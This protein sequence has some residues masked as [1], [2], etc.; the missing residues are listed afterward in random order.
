LSDNKNLK[1]HLLSIILLLSLQNIVFAQLNATIS[2]TE[3]FNCLGTPCNYSGPGILINEIMLSPASNDGSLSGPVG[4]NNPGRGEWIELYNPNLCEAVDISCYMLGNNAIVSNN[5]NAGGG[6]RIPPGTIVPPAGFVLLRGVNADPIPLNRLIQNGGNVIELIIPS[7]ITDPGVCVGQSGTR[8]WFP[9]AGGWFAFYDANGVPQDAI[10]WGSQANI[11]LEPCTPAFTGCGFNGTL[12]AYNNIPNNRKTFVTS[13]Q[14]GSNTFGLSLKRVPDGGTWGSTFSAPSLSDCN[15][16]CINLLT[17][18]CSGTATVVVTGGSGNYS[19]KWDDSQAQITATAINLCGEEY[20]VI[21]KDLTTL[22]SLIICVE[23]TNFE[24]VVSFGLIDTLCTSESGFFVSGGLPVAGPNEQGIYSGTGIINGVF[25]PLIANQGLNELKYTYTSEGGC[26]DSAFGEIYVYEPLIVSISGL[27]PTYCI[28]DASSQLS[29]NPAGGVISVTTGLSGNIFNPANALIGENLISYTVV[30]TNSCTYIDSAITKVFPKPIITHAP[31]PG[32]CLNETNVILS[33]ANPTGGTYFG[34]GI[35][36]NNNFEPSL[37]GVG[38]HTISYTYV[39]TAGCTDTISLSVEVFDVPTVVFNP[40]GDFCKS[41]SSVVLNSAS[42]L[43]GIY[44][45]NGV[46]NGVFNP[47]LANAGNNMITYSLTDSSGCIVR[48]TINVVVIDASSIIFSQLSD[49]CSNEA[50]FVLNIASPTGGV[51][52]GNGIVNGVFNPALANVGNNMIYYNYSDSIGCTGEDSISVNI[53]S[54][55]IITAEPDTAFCIGGCAQLSATEGGLSY[56]WSP[57][58]GLS[59]P[60]IANPTACP[61]QTTTYTVTVSL[62][63][64]NLVQNGDFSQ[65]NTGF[66]SAYTR[67]NSLLLS[68]RYNIV[69]DANNAYFTFQG[70][71]HT[72]PPNGLFMVVN[73]AGTTGVNVWCQTVT[74]APN[75]DYILSTW[76][77]SVVSTNP[78]SLRFRI[79]G[80]TQ[81]AVFSPPS[82][83]GDWVLFSRVWNSGNATTADICI[84]NMNNSAN[85]N[86]FGLDDISFSTICDGTAQVTVTVNPY[87]VLDFDDSLNVCVNNQ[88]FTLNNVTPTGGTYSGSG[89]VNGDFDP[90]LANIGNNTITYSYTDSIGCSAV[91]SFNILVNN[92]IDII[93]TD[94]DPVCVDEASFVLNNATPTGGI[95]SGSGVSNGEFNPSLANIGDNLITY[96]YADSLGCSGVDSFIIVVNDLPVISFDPINNICIDE[97]PFALNFAS[98]IGGTYSG[99]GIANGE[100]DPSLAGV[101]NHFIYYEYTDSLGCS[102]IDSIEIIVFELPIISFN[103]IGDFCLNDSSVLLNSATPI[104]GTYSGNGVLNGV[105]DPSLAGVGNHIIYYQYTDSNSCGAIDSIDVIVFDTPVI[106]LTNI[107]P[108]CVD[109]ASFVLNNA[110]P[111]GGTYS[112]SGVSNAEFNPSLANI[113]NN[114]IIYDYTDSLSCSAVDSFVIVVNDL[115]IISFNSI[116][117]ICIDENPFTL[118]FASPIGGTYSGNGIANVEFDPSLAGVGNHFIYYEFTDSLGCSNI[119]SVEIIVFELPIISFNSIGDFCLNDSS[120]LLSSATP[121]G[122]TYSGNGVLNGIFDPSL[123]GVGNHKIYYQYTDSNSCGAI[124]SIDVIV[125]DT[126]VINFSNINPV[127]VDEAPFTLNNATPIG[128]TYSGSGVSNAEFNP[129]LANIGNNIIIYNYT[130]SL[131]CS[132]VDSFIIVVNDLPIISFNSINNI[133]ID[134]NPFTLNFASP[135]GGTY[136]GNGIANGEF[137]PSLAGVGNHFIYYEFTDSLSCSNIDSVEIIVYPLPIISFN[138]IGDFCINDASI[139]LNSATPIGGTYSGNGVT[140]GEFNPSLAGSGNHFVYYEFTDSLGCS[141]TDSIEIIV[142]PSPIITFNAVGNF[143]IDDD[144]ISLNSATP[145]GGT[146]FGNGVTNGVFDPSL[147][148]VGNHNIF[149]QYADSNSCSAIDSI[150][151][152]VFDLP[153]INFSNINPVCVDASSFT[154]NNATPLGGIY[155]G[156]AVANGDFNPSLANIGNNII[157]YDYTDSLGCS[158]VDTFTIVVNDLPIISFDSINSY[159]INEDPITLNFASPIGGTY[160]GNGVVNSAFDP[161]LAGVGNHIITYTFTDLNGCTNSDTA[162]IIVYDFPAIT[163]PNLGQICVNNGIVNIQPV[164]PIGGILSGNGVTTNQF[165]PEIAGVGNHWIVYEYTDSKGCSNSDSIEVEVLDL[166]TIVFPDYAPLCEVA[167]PFILNTALPSGGIYSGNAI[168]GGIFS[169]GNANLGNN[170][171]YYTYTDSLGCSIT[172][173]ANILIYNITSPP[174]DFGA[175]NPICV[176]SVIPLNTG[177]P[178]GGVY[179]GSGVVNNTFDAS[180]VGSGTFELIYTYTDPDNCVNSDTTTITVNPLPVIS[181]NS[182]ADVCINNPA[183]NLNT[184]TPV[185]GTY[186]GNGVNNNQFNPSNAGLNTHVINYTFTDNNNCVNSDSATVLV[187][188]TTPIIFDNLSAVCVNDSSFTLN[189]ALPVGGIYSGPGVSNGIFNPTI[190]GTG[191][192]TLTYTFANANGCINSET[193]TI[194]VNALPNITFNNLPDVCIDETPFTLNIAT[195]TGGTYSGVG[196]SNNQFNPAV[197]GAGTHTI[198]YTFTNNNNCTNTKTATITVNPLPIVVFNDLADKCINNPTFNLNT[199][200]P[201]GGTYSGNGVNNNQFIPSVAGVGTHT[202]IYTFTDN[203]SCSNSDSASII[204]NDTTPI[205]FPDFAPI[206]IDETPFTLNTALPVGG[207]YSGSGVSNGIYNPAVAGVGNRNITYRYTNNFGCINTKVA[208]IRINA[209]PNITFNNLPDVCIDETPFTLNIAT[210]TGGTYSG[211]GVSNNQFNPAVAGAGTH[212]ITYTFTNNNNCTNTKTATITVNPLPIVVFND[213]ADKCINNP[214]FNLNTAT[215]TGGTYSG[216]GVNNNQ[217]IPSVAG[218][219]THT[220]IYTFTDNNSCSNSDSA[221]IIVNDTTPIIFPDFAPICIDETPFTLNTALPVG[222]VY[223]GSGVSNGIY[224][225]A[226]AGVGNRSITYRYTN[227]FGCINTKVARIRINALPNI[228]FNNLPDVCIDETPFALNTATPTGGTYSGVGVSNNQFN[229]A[230]AGVGTHTITYTFTNNNNCTNTKTATITVNPLPIIVFNDLADKCVNNPI[231]N[232]NTATPTGGI[233]SGNGVSNNQFSPS[234]AGVGTHIITYIFTDNNSCSNSDSATIIVNDT[235]PI[236]FADFAPICID[237]TPFTLNTATPT[238]GIY[239]GSGVSNGI[240]NPAVA[241]VGNR[242]ITYRY[243][244]NFGCINTKVARIRI[245]A[246]PNITFNN[247]LDVC[248]DETPFTLNTATPTGGTYSGV[249]VSNNQF[250][251]SI[252]GAGT[253]TITYTFTNNNNCTNTKTATI[254]V[255]PLPVLVFNDL[256]DKCINNPTFNLNTATPTSGTYSGNGVSNNQFSPSVAGVGT[257]II[258]YIFTDNNSCSNSDSATI[259]VNDT[260][261][262]IFPD[263]APICIDETPFT[264]NTASPTGGIY[265]GSGVSNGVYNPA[266]AGVGNRSVT[267]RY[268]NNFGCINTKVAR[269]RI[270]ALPNI[271]FNN[272]P[273]VCIDETPFTL[274]TATPTGGTYSGVGVSN[275]QFNPSIAGAG[276]HTITYTFTNN[277]NCTNTKTAIITVNPLPVVVFNDLADKCINNPILNLITATPSGG[278]YSGNGVSNN[279]FSPSVA[280]VGT[281]TITYIFT[282]NNSCSNLDSATIIVNDT[283]PIIFPDFAPI[284]IDEAPFTLSAA[285][286]TGGIYSGTGVSNGIYNPAVAGVGN[287]SIT[288]RYTNNFGCINTKVARIRINALPNITFNNLPDVCIDET[289]FTL[290]TATPTGGTYSG[291][292]VSNNQF[293]PAVAGAGTHTITYTFTNNNNCTNT[294][295]ATITVN[296]L[297]VVVFNNLADK[298]INNP[299]FNLNTATP[300]GGTYSGNGVSNNQFSPS[301]AGV[302]THTII[303]TF[304]DNNSCSN[305]DSASIIVNDTTP[306]IFPDFAPICIDETPFTLNTAS[307]TG[308]IYSGSGV[309]NGIYNPAVAGVGNRS[310]TYRY[311]NNFGCINTKMARIRINALPNITFNNLPDVCI[312]ETP[313][314]LNTATPTGGTYSGVGVSNNQFNP[315]IAGAGTHTITYTFT[316]NNNCTNTKTATITVNPLPVVVFNDLADKCINNPIFNLNTATPTGGIY[317]GNGVS[318]NQFSPS[319]AGVGTHT[320]IYI[321]TDN[322]SCSNSD[323]AT[324]IVNDTTP[325]IFPDF[326]PICINETPFTLN[327]ATPTGGIYTGS[328]VSNGIYNPAVAGVGNRS[329]TYRYTNNFGCINTKVARI[330][331]NA[332]PNI[333]FNNLPDVCV[334]ETPF[335]LNTATPTGGTYS[336]VGVSNNEFNPSVAGAGTHTITYSFTNT[337]NCTNTRTATIT[338]NPLPVVVFN[339]PN[340]VCVNSSVFNLNNVSPNGGTFSGTGVTNDQFNPSVA[341]AG[342]FI[343]TYTITDNNG[344]TNFDNATMV[345]NDTTPIVFNNIPEICEDNPPFTLVSASPTGGVYSGTGVLNNIFYPNT[346][347]VGT[348]EI[349][350]VYTNNFSCVNSKKNFVTVNPLPIV[351]AFTPF[352]NICPDDT[353]YIAV[354]GANNYFINP[355]F[356]TISFAND[357][358]DISQNLANTYVVT[359]IDL[360]GCQNKD[361]V[362]IGVF[363]LPNVSVTPP[364]DTICN[365]DSIILNA[366]GALNYNWFPDSVLISNNNDNILALP[367]SS[368]EFIVIGTDTNG[369][370][371]S[372]T[373]N[374]T[375]SIQLNISNV[376]TLCVGTS[377]VLTASE[378]GNYIWGPSS[379]LNTNVGQSVIASPTVTTTY[380]L[381][382]APKYGCP[383]EGTATVYVYQPLN[384]FAL[385]DTI[386]FNDTANVSAFGIGGDGNYSF[387]W[388][389]NNEFINPND[390]NAQVISQQTTNYTVIINDGCGSNSNSTTATVLVLPLPSISMN[391]SPLIGCQP[392]T[393]FLSHSSANGVSCAWYVDSL[394]FDN[395]CDTSFVFLD[396][397]LHSVTLVLE[398]T[399]GCFN[400]DTAEVIVLPRPIADFEHSFDPTTIIYPEVNFDGTVS[401]PDV[402]NWFWIFDSL[403]VGSGSQP[404]YLFENPHEYEVTLIVNNIEGCYDTITYIVDVKPDYAIY[405]PNAFTPNKDGKNDGFGPYGIGIKNGPGEYSMKIFNRW[406]E[407]IFESNDLNKFWNGIPEKS[408]NNQIAQNGIYVYVIDVIDI[409]NKK[410]QYTGKVTLLK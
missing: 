353:T 348:F 407:L 115:P 363:S 359:G 390:A 292:G 155:S 278:T 379:S 73:A 165:N 309:S 261:P 144:S 219:G 317:S 289:P 401:S 1:K 399:N 243:T 85:G 83:V 71:D 117:N 240:Y 84:Q 320:I 406:G 182:L 386:C 37:V 65:G 269:I 214:T 281:H 272:L 57:T 9:N 339:D 209:L 241:G 109:E 394:F 276:T 367:Y 296:P 60:S 39:D 245:N 391:V 27:N 373:A 92:F 222:G 383:N 68:G 29:F 67:N 36:A 282:D 40:I 17:S 184:A 42:P 347:G 6:Y 110:T 409:F 46:V 290:N 190:A 227:N 291:V 300:T 198:T 235:T 105:F 202:I 123:A 303:Y 410:H 158:A 208:R 55:P 351:S 44:A 58:T 323:S 228:T 217:F 381:L 98:P 61:T 378:P 380:F 168:V 183:F 362:S 72:N 101:G 283:T 147:A 197:A 252:A 151:I 258:T 32:I 45:G 389:P 82:T 136:S 112:G 33:G 384:V 301:A 64:G 138:S 177:I 257:H 307:P 166:P 16:S 52:S 192:K 247:L 118:N 387:E 48:D 374:I 175:L 210:P 213:L 12:P 338:V 91:D 318:N 30:D 304:T 349:T 116:N 288:Y 51:Y 20:C 25:D 162:S 350:Y 273:D 31:V 78:A 167:S 200:T 207:V 212:T 125:F 220:I 47:N 287:R 218:V 382:G 298:C 361:S 253:H 79:N 157:T 293:N 130:D 305:S 256:A 306:I 139:L 8:L 141:N 38:N 86:S 356:N 140:N 195:P 24:P 178:S 342:T 69:S 4:G 142:F 313:F 294:R 231:F 275:N 271:T 104:G 388:L 88:A 230:V 143:C 237:E 194:R 95:Y 393:T 106:N 248:I 13:T 341:G 170:T 43:G 81:G 268:T 15:S 90:S 369:C 312:D 370:K 365:G 265:T 277:N 87:P 246:L 19:Y 62:P 315:S 50:P 94:I 322:N 134:E 149:Y 352:N 201:T 314:T 215:P 221:S 344:C 297:P 260:T 299:T 113:G 203:N 150:E 76:V 21:V 264:L 14:A 360:K 2:Y 145:V 172:D 238:G 114:I 74:V 250:N 211:V 368:T 176:D 286:P 345:V 343:L 244:N 128:G 236:I 280:G 154:L 131:S 80:V 63:S 308:G 233:Y 96:N 239:S 327:T 181:F 5:I 120:I 331:I 179:S 232:L 225:P 226:V 169:P 405:I 152:I 357:T 284:C 335:A 377:V 103:S 135:T 376:D 325:I 262:I 97:N 133:C 35:N 398:G 99:N 11:S 28:D 188:D 340:D 159:C 164:N 122:G 66:S 295:T 267:Y 354:A 408:N 191:N 326:A 10:S 206:C 22:D 358:F 180:I 242:N 174:V 59:N 224:N 49:V 205:I 189:T 229:P 199:A 396:S 156:I 346:S 310:V 7:E 336:G 375:V 129:S 270:N 54:S 404:S 319:V 254:T 274:N 249:G 402:I 18:S 333:T 70:L 53:I 34:N 187:N 124:D 100:F 89:V 255:N 397:G 204:V 161:G 41:D 321:F 223:S 285:T 127:C 171:I 392:L 132:A 26:T 119:D 93:L 193:A 111:I 302:G 266:V 332:L 372:D 56:S 153:L 196:V 126:P 371:N 330:R 23:V 102:N 395:S 263:F 337:N 186:S 403:G 137:D 385:G 364:T 107:N 146:Y 329:I 160:S 334:D 173:S 75:T 355:S 328:G 163:L 148:G 234:A 77:S 185:G 400:R 251:P 316:N 108:V 259:I 366:N 311:T 216:N 121:I 279:Q 3:N 324:I